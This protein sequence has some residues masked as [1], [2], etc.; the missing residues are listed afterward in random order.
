M[1]LYSVRNLV[2]GKGYIGQTIRPPLK[3]WK[4]HLT[5]KRSG[6][7]LHSA[8][9]KYGVENFRFEP[10]MEF[11]D[12][13]ELDQAEIHMIRACRTL[14]TEHGYNLLIGGR[15]GPI[16]PR[17]A[18]DRAKIS[19]ALK[20]KKHSSDHVARNR[21]AHSTPE[22]IART[23]QT[24]LGRKRSPETCA[25]MAAAQL[26]MIRP[27][28]R[29]PPMLGR[30]HSPETKARMSAAQKG[31][32]RGPETR[33]KISAARTGVPKSEVC[34]EKLRTAALAQW[35]ARRS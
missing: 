31:K 23:V 11:S 6:R 16:G 29:A 13:E 34:R 8:I 32:T 27:V 18:E 4:Q 9:R 14:T 24:H 19:A 30:K 12:R 2:D 15:R 20:G 35:S 17:S 21:E 3:R 5:E 25:R 7:P 22:A 10:I 28:D 33:A 1:I 26:E